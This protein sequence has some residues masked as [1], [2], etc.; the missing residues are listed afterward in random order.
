[1]KNATGN[2]LA[3]DALAGEGSVTPATGG[4][5]SHWRGGS[6]GAGTAVLESPRRGAAVLA[7]CGFGLNANAA[8]QV[9][10]SPD[11]DVMTSGFFS[12][13]NRVRGYAGEKRNVHRVSTAQPFGVAGACHGPRLDR[14]RG[15]GGRRAET[16]RLKSAKNRE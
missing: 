3:C 9:T 10:P 8:V 11:E 14:A 13:A 7:L 6:G 12:G 1:M 4:A 16:A 2:A 5:A 15:G